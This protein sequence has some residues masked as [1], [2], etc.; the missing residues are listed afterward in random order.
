MTATPRIYGDRAVRIA[1]ADSYIVSSMDDE[2][3]FGPEFYHLSFGRA[4]DEDLLTDYKVIALT[5]PQD[6]VSEVYQR[7]M[8]EEGE[9]FTVTESARIIG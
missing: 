9:G 5:M 2:T 6:I 3:V 4:I 8:T 1:N 7:A